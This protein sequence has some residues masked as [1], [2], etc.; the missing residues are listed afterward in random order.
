MIAKGYRSKERAKHDR[1]RIIE[2][3]EDG[4]DLKAIGSV[5]GVTQSMVN[6]IVVQQLGYKRM[7]LSRD[8]QA[9]IHDHR[10][11]RRTHG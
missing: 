2:M 1:E 4:Y 3:L 5:I 10:E 6:K 7:L 8:E 9:L 11:S